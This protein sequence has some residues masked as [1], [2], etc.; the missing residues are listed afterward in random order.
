MLTSVKFPG[1]HCPNVGRKE[2]FNKVLKWQVSFLRRGGRHILWL[3]GPL[4][5]KESY[6]LTDG[7]LKPESGRGLVQTTSRPVAGLE[8]E[9]RSPDI[10][11]SARFNPS[12]P[13]LKAPG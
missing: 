5:T 2:L 6:V 3:K 7:K 11:T 4:E 10:P 1:L 9:Y 8:P 13:E 12:Q